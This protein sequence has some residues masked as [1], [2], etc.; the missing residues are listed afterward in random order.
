MVCSK[1]EGRSEPGMAAG[2][3]MTSTAAAEERLRF[4]EAVRSMLVIGILE[5]MLGFAGRKIGRE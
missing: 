1:Q 4:I 3:G 5:K 2:I